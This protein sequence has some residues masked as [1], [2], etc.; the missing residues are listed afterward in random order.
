MKVN[1]YFGSKPDEISIEVMRYADGVTVCEMV[2]N[3]E[4]DLKL[5]RG[6]EL[7]HSFVCSPSELGELCAGWLYTEGYSAE[8]VTVSEDGHTATADAVE[9][10]PADA[11]CL[12]L[13]E[14]V[15][16]STEEM[17]ALFNRASDK[18]SRSHGIHECVLK[19]N[20]W[21]ILRTDIGRHNAIDKAV[22]TALLKGYDLKGAVMFSSGRINEQTVRK[23]VRC[24]ISCL[25]S[26]AVITRQALHLAEEL[27][28]KVFFSVKND[29]YMTK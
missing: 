25:M 10:N 9:G 1:D 15:S 18:Y 29:S 3:E 23:A 6:G 14:T 27:G 28:L 2:L 12:E 4:H 19:G 5:F 21:D 13:T 17:L 7:L 11:G 20:G 26:K 16:A 8:S 24:G 22:G